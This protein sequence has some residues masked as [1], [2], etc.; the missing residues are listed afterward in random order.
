MPKLSPPELFGD[1]EARWSESYN[2]IQSG[3]TS[4]TINGVNSKK[5][6][7]MDTT[8]GRIVGKIEHGLTGKRY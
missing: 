5:S 6:L 4:I 7:I 3:K 8:D 1:P 2:I